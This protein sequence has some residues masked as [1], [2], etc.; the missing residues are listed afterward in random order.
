MMTMMMTMIQLIELNRGP[1]KIEVLKSFVPPALIAFP[2][3]GMFMS[4]SKE[5]N[6]FSKIVAKNRESSVKCVN[7]N[8]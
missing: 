7:L 2:F 8:V 3:C 4:S 1:V 6:Y 5:E